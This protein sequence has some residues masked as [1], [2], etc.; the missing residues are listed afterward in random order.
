M[1]HLRTFESFK[2]EEP[3]TMDELLE[4]LSV[5]E[6]SILD[7]VQAELLNI[8]SFIGDI[9]ITDLENLD[10][11]SEFQKI[12]RLKNLKRGVVEL[13]DD[14]ETFLLNPFKFLLVRYNNKTDLQDPDYI[15]IQT[16]NSTQQ[17]WNSVKL[18]QING[19][20]SNFYDKLTNRTIE[21]EEEGESFL[22]QTSNKNEWELVNREET[23]NFPK[24]VRKEELL[25]I[26]DRQGNTA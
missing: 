19:E 10:N 18:Y 11:N 7:S 12:L 17:D 2:I 24:F 8:E 14:Y 5:V 16:F 1:K 22:Y 9:D 4:K 3:S 26:L 21:I 13:T 25:K 23:E 20:F 6:K 15:F